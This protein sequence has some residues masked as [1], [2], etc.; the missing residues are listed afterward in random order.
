MRRAAGSP[1]VLRRVVQGAVPRLGAG[2]W[3]AMA[4]AG[5]VA[6]LVVLLARAP[7]SFAD[8]AL[9][10][11]TEGRV[12]LADASG[13][14][15]RGRGRLLLADVAPPSIAERPAGVPR[16]AAGVVI[17]GAFNWR[18]SFW[19]LL[20]GVLD[21]RIEHDSMRQPVLLT[22]RPGELRATPGSI[23]LPPVAL[24]RLGS[25]WN[26]IRPTGALAVTW[27]NVTV[28]AGRFDGR[29]TIELSQVASALTPVRPLGA[30]RIEVVG[31]GANAQVRMNTLAGPLRLEGSGTWNARS[32]L[33]F[34]AEATVDEVERARL[35]PLLFLMGRRDGN[36]TLMMIGA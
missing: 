34:A 2:W 30:Y 21:A 15:W 23:T 18:V 20:V 27:D 31:A 10:R 5:L 3:A 29:G 35:E 4:V 11:A 25:P 1:G 22:G 28:R 17:P 19:P 33:R 32:G 13:T 12:R 7:A 36:R 14:L 6:M 9:A 16:V 24:D 26:T 8:A